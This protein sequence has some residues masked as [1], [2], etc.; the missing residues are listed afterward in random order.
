MDLGQDRPLESRNGP[1]AKSR[2]RHSGN[3]WTQRTPAL[4]GVWGFRF[5]GST[6]WLNCSSRIHAL[7]ALISVSH[8]IVFPVS[9]PPLI[10]H[11]AGNCLGF[12][13]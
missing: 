13:T 5:V 9:W 8:V 6:T 10:F 7:Q 12:E 3:R 4:A 2:S 1:S 11:H